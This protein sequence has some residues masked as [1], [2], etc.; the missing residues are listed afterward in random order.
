MTNVKKPLK[1]SQQGLSEAF[2]GLIRQSC[3]KFDIPNQ[4]QIARGA[5]EPEKTAGFYWH[6]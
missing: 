3:K 4:S 5:D 6:I 2:V 1:I